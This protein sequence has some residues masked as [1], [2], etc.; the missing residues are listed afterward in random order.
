MQT[1]DVLGLLPGQADEPIE[2]AVALLVHR[3]HG[4]VEVPSAG[5]VS[6]GDVELDPEDRL[7]SGL[8]RGLLQL[9]VRG[10]VAVLGECERVHPEF[11]DA[12]DVCLR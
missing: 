9:H 1:G 3:Q 2:V 5:F 10:D 11:L 4:L 8:V 12:S 7:D 6:G